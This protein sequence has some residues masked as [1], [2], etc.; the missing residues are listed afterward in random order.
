MPRTITY[1]CNECKKT[2]GETN[3][4]WLIIK[5]TKS[6]PSGTK[7]VSLVIRPFEEIQREQEDIEY[8]CGAVCVHKVVSKYLEGEK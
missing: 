5:N 6:L 4:W 7:T 2:K 3:H 8:L 1:T